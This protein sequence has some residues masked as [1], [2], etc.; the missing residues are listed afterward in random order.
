MATNEYH[1]VTDWRVK[2]TL[3][4]VSEILEDAL[5]LP[6]WWPS[7]YLEVEELE[8]GDAR[9]KGRV[10]ALLTKGWLPYTLR[11]KFRITESR[12]PH[13]FSLR[14][15]GDFEGTG[16]WTFTQ[17]GEFVHII[18]DWRIRADKPLL[19]ALSF[20]LKP[21]FSANHRWAMARGLDSLVLEL[22]RRRARTPE[23]AAR[24][25][26]PPAPTFPHNLRHRK[27]RVVASHA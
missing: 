11:W 16:R 19:K 14:A 18:Y 7:V 5:A 23:E 13:G 17:D 3:E 2:G 26:P 27:R 15:F 24:V 9:G 12:H 10:I 22:E 4:E 6:R 20:L 1:F 8:A 25:P 21:I